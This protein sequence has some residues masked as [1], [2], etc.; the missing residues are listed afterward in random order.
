MSEK[1]YT[2]ESTNKVEL[3]GLYADDVKTGAVSVGGVQQLG[4]SLVGP[5]SKTTILQ[6]SPWTDHA[7]RP[8]HAHR[9][10]AL[11]E[12]TE[13]RVL[14]L[15]FP[16]QGPD[17][18]SLDPIQRE[19]FKRQGF[20]IVG[21]LGWQAV[22]RILPDF[23]D[24]EFVLLGASQGAAHIAG[25]I[26]AKPEEATV[27]DVVMY[28]NPG[29]ER[30]SVGRL[31]L[32]F[33]T[34]GGKDATYYTRQNPEWAAPDNAGRLLGQLLTQFPS[35]LLPVQ[36]MAKG[37][38]EEEMLEGFR[39]CFNP[40]EL[41]YLTVHL[42]NGSESTVS[43]SSVNERV[44]D[45]INNGYSNAKHES[46]RGEYHALQNSFPAFV[47]LVKKALKSSI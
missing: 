26:H 28:E 8:F 6:T 47:G 14:T 19:R 18:H 5:E 39:E 12:A 11:A 46:L 40:G 32:D 20:N 25:M 31:A 15:D 9:A 27:S 37:D 1:R 44:A 10:A 13:S 35:H 34:N 33:L 41:K 4:W 30:R 7:S 21:K 2:E 3:N 22:Q 17:S 38:S 42:F 36:M 45:R 29:F 16:G 43:T 23:K 24:E